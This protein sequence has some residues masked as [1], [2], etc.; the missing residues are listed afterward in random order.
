MISKSFSVGILG[1][2]VGICFLLIG[3]VMVKTGNPSLIHS[4]HIVQVPRSRLSFVAR[5]VGFGALL[6]GVGATLMGVCAFVIENM[7]SLVFVLAA[8]VM[9]VGVGVALAT[10]MV[11]TFRPWS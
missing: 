5:L 6:I 9:V 2:G 4:Y 8:V 7:T 1:I 3:A 11:F 10:V